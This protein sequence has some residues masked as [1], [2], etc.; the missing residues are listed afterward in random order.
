MTLTNRAT[1]AQFATTTNSQGE[2]QFP[3]LATS[4]Y[5]L[6]AEAPGFKKSNVSSVLVQVDQVT[7]IDLALE[8]GSLTEMVQV[9]AV[10]PL[11][12]NEKSTISSVV[13]TRTIRN[14]PLNARQVLD[15]ALLNPGPSP[16]GPGPPL[17]RI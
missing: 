14:M 6:A 17:S 16:S 15:L 4:T 8:I 1:N 11:L 7:H 2:F 10:A 9:E 13:D 12:E 3:Q 5:N